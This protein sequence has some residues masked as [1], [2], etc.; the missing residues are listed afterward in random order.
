MYFVRVKVV[1]PYSNT[2][3]ATVWKKSYFILSER[4]DFHMF[5]NLLIVSYTFARH[6]L[7]LLSVD[8]ILLLRYVN[9][10][11]F[12]GLP[13]KVENHFICIYIKDNASCCLL[14][15]GIQLWQVHL[16]EALDH[17]PLSRYHQLIFLMDP[18]TWTHQCWLTNNDLYHL[19]RHWMLFRGLARS[20][21]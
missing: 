20:D 16:Q 18:Y 8:E 13:I 19:C 3:T 4:P 2:D 5:D 9:R 14:Q 12:R 6:Q 7:T 1:H 21:G 10:S 11:N 17:L 15:I